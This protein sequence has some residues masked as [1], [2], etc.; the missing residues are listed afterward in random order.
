[1]APYISPM[2]L[3]KFVEVDIIINYSGGGDF[4]FKGLHFAMVKLM[5]LSQNEAALAWDNR[6]V[7]TSII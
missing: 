2:K 6:S 4:L 5:P 3:G 7:A 1:M